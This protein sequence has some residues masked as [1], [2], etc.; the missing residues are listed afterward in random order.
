M[1][2]SDLL[3]SQYQGL[4]IFDS[5][6]QYPMTD[7]QIGQMV[8][9]MA[10]YT[11]YVLKFYTGA[12]APSDRTTGLVQTRNPII[13]AAP[14]TNDTF[15]SNAAATWFPTATITISGQTMTHSMSNFAQMVMGMS[16]VPFTY[17]L[18][19][20]YGTSWC[21]AS[22]NFWDN[23]NNNQFNNMQLALNKTSGSMTVTQPGFTPTAGWLTM[24]AQDSARRYF[25]SVWV[26]Q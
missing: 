22:V 2:S 26:L 16:A 18:P 11:Q 7:T 12:T 20:A 5:W 9:G 21:D 15:S 1:C 6:G 24:E 23:N 4:Q 25:R 3:D 14:V 8:T 19:T 13:M 17:T 10:G